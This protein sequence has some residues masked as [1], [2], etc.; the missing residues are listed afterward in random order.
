MVYFI[1]EKPQ[2]AFI[3]MNNQYILTQEGFKKL[4]E[5]LVLFQQEKR[6][7]AVERLKKAREMGDLSENSE[8]VAAKDEL[9]FVDG[10]IAEIEEILKNSE[11]KQVSV[12]KSAV[13]IG[14]SVVVSQNGETNTYKIVGEHE[15]DIMNG[16]L[17][18][19]SP[20]GGAL[21]GKHTG[22][23]INAKTPS[24]AVTYKIL[25]IK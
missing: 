25:E 21:L 3:F 18:H 6:P 13:E 4:E 8:Y 23:V 20:I 2:G 1:T 17:S 10:K 16:K 9:G 19:K 5:E 15:A 22:D 7:K 24:G 12:D 11:V 14:D